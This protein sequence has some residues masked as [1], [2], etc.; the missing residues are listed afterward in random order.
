MNPTLLKEINKQMKKLYIISTFATIAMLFQSCSKGD[1]D[2]PNLNNPDFSKVYANGTNLEATASSLYNTLYME[3]HAT[4]GVQPMLAV[5]ADNSTC[6]WGNYGMQ[7]M[8]SEPR[9]VAWTN[10]AAYAYNTNTN[11]YFEG[12]YGAINPAADIIKAMDGGIKIANG[13]GDPRAKAFARF[14]MGVGYG[15]LAL[16]FD[17]SYVVDEAKTA[18]GKLSG[19]VPYTEVATAALSYLD[20][21]ITIAKANTFSIPSTWLGTPA[22]MSNVDFVKLCSTSAARIMAYMPRSKTQLAAVDW[23]KV[24]AYA[25]AGITSDFSIALDNNLWRY[26]TASTLG[27]GE[28][29]WGLTDMYVVNMMDPAQPAH[30]DNSASFPYPGQSTN[31]LDRRLITDHTYVK[32]NG[33][34]VAR[35]YYHFSAYRNTR[36]DALFASTRVG[37][38]PEIMKEENDLIRAEARAYTADLPGAAAIVNAGTHTTRGQLAPVAPIQAAIVAAIH[39]ERCIELFLTGANLA[40]YEMRKLDLL[41]KGTPLH[42]PLP[43]KLLETM[44]EPAPYYTFGTEARADGTGTSN[45]GW[46]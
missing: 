21:A 40:F 31:P 46:R 9:N 12:Q 11:D 19:A 37:L 43:A 4:G 25:D 17:R 20:E 6:S 7:D 13:T 33:F 5:A 16:V 24:K 35:G 30:W 15:N 22:N 1:L 8:S 41:Q 42:L 39:K 14:V 44:A 45:G 36:Y 3:S 26:G 38:H 29:G 32:S 10:T 34:Q 23:A 2:I 18:E 27:A 28:A